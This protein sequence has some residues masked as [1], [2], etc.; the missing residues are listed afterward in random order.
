MLCLSMYTHSKNNNLLQA[1]YGEL[2]SISQTYTWSGKTPWAGI[3]LHMTLRG[4]T[5]DNSFIELLQP[6]HILAES[7]VN[8]IGFM[9]GGEYAK[10]MRLLTYRETEARKTAFQVDG[11]PYIPSFT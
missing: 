4:N 3:P 10:L 2:V 6:L 8:D 11:E 7:S 5:A 1:R 9:P